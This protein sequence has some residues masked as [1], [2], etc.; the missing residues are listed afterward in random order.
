MESPE[1]VDLEGRSVG[2]CL[3]DMVSATLPTE[4][5]QEASVSWILG[6]QRQSLGNE[7]ETSDDY[8]KDFDNPEWA[9]GALICRDMMAQ[10]RPLASFFFAS[11]IHIGR[12]QSV[13]NYAL[14]RISRL[15]DEQNMTASAASLS[16]VLLSPDTSESF[17]ADLLRRA[18]SVARGVQQEQR[19]LAQRWFARWLQEVDPLRRAVI[20]IEEAWG[21]L[22]SRPQ[23]EYYFPRGF[24]RALFAFWSSASRVGLLRQEMEHSGIRFRDEPGQGAVGRPITP[25]GGPMGPVLF[26][27]LAS[28]HDREFWHFEWRHY[29]FDVLTHEY[30]APIIEKLRL[31]YAGLDPF[32]EY[33]AGGKPA[34]RQ[35]VALIQENMLWNNHESPWLDAWRRSLPRPPSGHEWIACATFGEAAGGEWFEYADAMIKEAMI[36]KR[37][38]PGETWELFVQRRFNDDFVRSV[39]T[40][41]VEWN[42]RS[43]ARNPKHSAVELA[44]LMGSVARSLNG[45]GY[46]LE[47]PSLE[48]MRQMLGESMDEGTSEGHAVV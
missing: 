16:E 11:L 10:L 32:A 15:E 30:G 33:R 9:V 35:L 19:Q 47:P 40:T 27:A 39:T 4:F 12:M 25:L 41:V 28:R 46:R 21:S 5:G 38:V 44:E 42:G 29:F 22:Q 14:S 31:K 6:M 2:S 26:A 20:S 7:D 43:E 8:I 1:R 48:F 37:P 18:C 17:S 36:H 45:R 3:R 24:M 34:D 23:G 13:S